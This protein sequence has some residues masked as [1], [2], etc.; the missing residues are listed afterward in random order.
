MSDQRAGFTRTHPAETVPVH[1]AV[2]VDVREPVA[3]ALRVQRVDR[4]VVELA[5]PLVRDHAAI[6][7]RRSVA[8]STSN[9][10]SSTRPWS[11][12]GVWQGD[13]QARTAAVEPGVDRQ[14][15]VVGVHERPVDLVRRHPELVRDDAVAVHDL[16]AAKGREQLIRD[17]GTSRAKA[18]QDIK[19]RLP[20]SSG[21]ACR[22][23]RRSTKP[24]RP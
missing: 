23:T 21:L 8:L 18:L 4:R 11:G 15:L 3:E 16:A 7:V 6:L 24:T 13:D 10:R 9:S 17:F 5:A 12:S 22:A 2:P 20:A 1:L 19:D 14:H